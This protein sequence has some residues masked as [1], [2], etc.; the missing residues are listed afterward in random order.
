MQVDSSSASA[1]NLSGNASITAAQTLIVGGDLVSGNASFTHTPTLHDTGA[2]VADP[3][4]A[5]AVPTGGTSYA[6]VNLSGNGTLT[7]N[8]G[9]YP[10]ISVSGNAKLILTPG[11]YLIGSGGVTISGNATVTNTTAA[12]GRGC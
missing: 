5:L 12:G 6:A 11:I 10:S 9:V 4:A 8:P 7:I 1:V 2:S 3:L